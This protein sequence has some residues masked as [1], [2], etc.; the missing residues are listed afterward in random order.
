M[1]RTGISLLVFA[2][3]TIVIIATA[4]FLPTT[5]KTELPH[6]IP[7]FDNAKMVAPN[8]AATLEAVFSSIGYTLPSVQSGAK[9]VPNLYIRELPPDFSKITDIKRRKALFIKTILPLAL[10]VNDR[11]K[12]YRDT[13]IELDQ[14]DRTLTVQE[15]Q[16]VKSIA[17]LHKSPDQA[18]GK[19]LS[20]IG[21]LPV[22]LIIAQAAVE[23]GWGTSRFATEGNA[24]FGQWTWKKGGGIIPRE[25]E[26]GKTYAVKSYPSLIESVWDYAYNLNTSNSYQKFREAR[27]QRIHDGLTLNAISL[28]KNLKNYSQKGDAYIATLR[29]VIKQNN[30]A[31]FNETKSEKPT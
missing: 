29:E 25:R 26:D 13:L 23:S 7:V 8:T 24:L 3:L 18:P 16:W 10:A 9:L 30:L 27:A 11:L 21:P 15:R 20:K 14:P 2:L 31:T 12:K 5:Q 28:I 22:D 4:L 1:K 17:K 6:I 19:L